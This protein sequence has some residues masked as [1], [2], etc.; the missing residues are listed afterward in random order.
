MQITV[1]QLLVNETL[2]EE[3]RD[4]NRILDK[5]A[6]K[7][8]LSNL[9]K[10]HPDK[11]PKIL[12]DLSTVGWQVAARSGGYSISTKDLQTSQAAKKHRAEF[13]H[14]SETIYRNP[15]LTR[16]QK[17]NAII[18]LAVET[19]DK[20]R[21]DV[22][23]ELVA[24]ENPAALQVVS[25]A[26]GNKIALSALLG[27]DMLYTG[28]DSEPV[29]FP[30][31]KNYSEG[32]EPLEY[33][34]GAFGARRG[35]IDPKL[36]TRDAG[37]LAKQLV[38]VSHRGVVTADDADEESTFLRG[39]PATTDDNDNIG[40]L[41]A[42]SIG[43]Y[44]RN[45]VITDNVLRNLAKKGIKN[46]LVRS[47]IVGG[48]WDGSLYAKDVGMTDKGRLPVIG[49][50]PAVTAVQALS[51][52]LSQ[53]ALCLAAG[54]LIRMAD[55]SVK[56]IELIKIGDMVLGVDENR[57]AYPVR[58]LN[59]F[60]N[61][62]KQCWRTT[63]AVGQSK[64]RIYL[65]STLDHKIYGEARYWA[66]DT[67][68]VEAGEFPV[69]HK[70]VKLCGYTLNGVKIS[71]RHDVL[72]FF[73]EIPIYGIKYKT[74]ANLLQQTT[75]KPIR[76]VRR[77]Y[78]KD[79]EL[80]GDRLTYDL[81]VD[82]P[83]H[84]FVLA[85]G[86]LVHNSSKHTGG[87]YGAFAAR[88]VSGFKTVNQLI[89]V[90]KVYSGGAAHAQTDGTVQSIEKAAAGGYYIMING[91][92][93]FVPNDQDLKV[94]QGDVVEAGDI[95]SDGLPNPAEVVRHKGIGEGRRYFVNTML[96]ACK[97]AGIGISKRNIEMLARGLV[98]H[99]TINKEY[100]DWLPDET[101]PY[102]VLEHGYEPREGAVKIKPEHAKNQYLEH[103]ILHY[104]VGTKIRP[105]VIKT[106]HD[107]GIKEVI[108]HK[109]PPPFETEM[110][111]GQ[112]V[113]QH[114]PDWLVRMYGSGQ[115]R[116][117]LEAIHRNRTTNPLGTSFVPALIMGV[118]FNKRVNNKPISKV[119]SPITNLPQDTKA[120]RLEYDIETNPFD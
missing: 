119:T 89:Q 8:L 116:G 49:E 118:D 38:Q 12:K 94:K 13:Q 105:S 36:A 84:L 11:Y 81:E 41:L 24:A 78:R 14:K 56:P 85:N 77:F 40:R 69:G 52:P 22:Y 21:N 26:K 25:G 97:N 99:V 1:G 72:T 63:F 62:L 101:V 82:S 2:P 3:Y 4:T 61:G 15:E 43:G 88:A 10:T 54:T 34:A 20:L 114:D 80:L 44:D 65:E 91:A 42:H 74:F 28:A 19:A 73:N 47:P 66:P 112:S 39:L 96:H 87:V 111:R 95:L 106:L 35:V 83:N 100:K 27:N 45:T 18:E 76:G 32:L 37:Y 115:K 7:S 98:N 90:P 103:P 48:P 51:E 30:V 113:L 67:E 71:K 68:L 92:K 110:I 64:E 46:I 17:D 57:V 16:K 109:E 29:P 58:V 55:F 93:H 70:C 5:K 102:G 9:A 120:P 75:D 107:H 108:T 104:T 33:W 31:L 59:R 50:N 117:I 23:D 86:L 6:I 60:D 53:G 79:Q